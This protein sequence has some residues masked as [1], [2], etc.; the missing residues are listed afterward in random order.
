MIEIKRG[1]VVTYT[2]GKKNLVNKP[3][4]YERYFE[5][6]WNTK[7]N[8][9]IAKIQR[10]VKKLWFYELKTIYEGGWI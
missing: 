7:N 9:K 1:D 6:Y 3:E 4:N 5:N 10:Y 2:N 8:L